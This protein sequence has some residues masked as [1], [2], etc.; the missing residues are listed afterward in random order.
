MT[1]EQTTCDEALA[2]AEKTFTLFD[3]VGIFAGCWSVGII[4]NRDSGRWEVNGAFQ[5]AERGRWNARIA[6]FEDVDVAVCFEN[7]A[8]D[9]GYTK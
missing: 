1:T 7:L 3:S 8:R 5:S 2:L 9:A 6:Q 4:F